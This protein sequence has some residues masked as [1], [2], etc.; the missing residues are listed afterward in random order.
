MAPMVSIMNPGGDAWWYLW[1]P[2]LAQNT[3]MLHVLKGEPLQ[4]LQVMPSVL[5]GA[6]LTAV[7]LLFVAR[8]MRAAVAR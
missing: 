3:L 5:V 1:L 7:G 8:S 6:V 4:W 2:G